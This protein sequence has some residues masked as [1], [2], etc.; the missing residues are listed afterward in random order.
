M[1]HEGPDQRFR[2]LV[3]YDRHLHPARV[4]QPAR[5]KVH[6]LLSTVEKADLDVTE[7][8][9]GEFP[10]Q[11]LKADNGRVVFGRSSRINS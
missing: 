2:P 10:R 5:E 6:P 4:L 9:L 11:A 8:V 1:I 3:G 7:I